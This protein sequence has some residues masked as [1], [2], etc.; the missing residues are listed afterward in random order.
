MKSKFECED[1][2]DGGWPFENKTSCY[3]LPLKVPNFGDALY[4]STSCHVMLHSPRVVHALGLGVHTR[5]RVHLSGRDRPDRGYH[6]HIRAVSGD[7]ARQG[8][9]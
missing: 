7:A 9:R 3:Q 2:G 5:A 1:C 8:L 6:G 4:V